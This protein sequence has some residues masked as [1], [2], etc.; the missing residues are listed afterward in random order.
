MVAAAYENAAN[1]QS[2]LLHDAPFSAQ[3]R[4]APVAPPGSAH[5]VSPGMSLYSL[6]PIELNGS[7]GDGGGDGGDGG[8]GLHGE[9]PRQNAVAFVRHEGLPQFIFHPGLPPHPVTALSMK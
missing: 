7:G 3:H 6:A 9:H 2:G 5:A 4:T 8:D 1:E